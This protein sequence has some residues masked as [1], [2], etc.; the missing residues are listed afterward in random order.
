M[1]DEGRDDG[2]AGEK[3]ERPP[4]AEV[5]GAGDDD[6]IGWPNMLVICA[7]ERCGCDDGG[8]EEVKPLDPPKDSAPP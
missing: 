3:V 6:C 7:L 4:K 2:A 1:A 5:G 8:G